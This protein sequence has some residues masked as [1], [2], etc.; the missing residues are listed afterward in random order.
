MSIIEYVEELSDV[1][2]VA[3]FSIEKEDLIE[4]YGEDIC[5][6]PFAIAIGHKMLEDIIEKIPLTYNNDEFAQEYLDEYFNSHQRVSKIAKKIIKYIEDEG[7]EAIELDV[8]GSNPLLNLKMPF[9]NKASA[10]IS[11]IGWLGK[12]NLLTTKE[13]GPRITW[14]TILT[15]APLSQYAGK[16]IKSLCGSCDLC[17]KACPGNA[18]KDLDNPK[19]SY[20]PVKCGKYLEKRKEEG[21]PVAC[22]MCLYICPYGNERSRKIMEESNS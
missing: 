7:F 20:D 10:N 17:V 18:I 21:H 6:Y 11:G 1:Y 3:D 8:S 19:E 15:N 16:P 14:A 5:K 13:F 9:S 4:T 2:G 22:G 12:N